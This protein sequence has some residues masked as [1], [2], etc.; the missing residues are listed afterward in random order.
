MNQDAFNVSNNI[1][2]TIALPLTLP[3]IIYIEP[4][5]GGLYSFLVDFITMT[6]RKK[7]IIR[8]TFNSCIK[9]LLVMFFAFLIQG[10]FQPYIT[11][12]TSPIFFIILLVTGVLF[13]IFAN[14]L[15]AVAF[16]L[17][18]K[19][20][21]SQVINSFIS[22]VKTSRITIFL[23]II[24]VFIFHYFGIIGIAIST[25]LIYFIK[26]IINFR[27]ILDNELPTFTPAANAEIQSITGTKVK[28]IARTINDTT[29]IPNRKIVSGPIS[30][31]PYI[32]Q[33]IKFLCNA[34]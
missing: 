30:Y 19:R 9:G 18:M 15:I 20:I 11:D 7:E 1:T 10:G 29:I 14:T 4:V 28:K 17:Q 25:F 32:S 22:T 16:L 21:D 2:T 27:S 5:V 8:V 13:I 23:G 6:S 24:N 34:L 12:I 31:P 33:I 26:P 3:A